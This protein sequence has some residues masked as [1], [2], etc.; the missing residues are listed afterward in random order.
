MWRT[1]QAKLSS[2]SASLTPAIYPI[3][4]PEPWV[5][6]RKYFLSRIDGCSGGNGGISIII[7]FFYILY[8]M[9]LPPLPPLLLWLNRREI[10]RV[11][12]FRIFFLF[13]RA[14]DDHHF[15]GERYRLFQ[16]TASDLRLDRQICR[17]SEI[18]GRGDVDA[19]RTTKG[20]QRVFDQRRERYAG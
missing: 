2:A 7:I 11:D 16:P 4:N 8:F 10:E 6:Q 3:H 13:N 18:R 5:D 17:S 20:H 1:R 9:E 19:I 15:C 14:D 12:A